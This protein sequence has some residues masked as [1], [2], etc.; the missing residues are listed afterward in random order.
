MAGAKR[1]EVTTTINVSIAGR[2]K[3]AIENHP[4]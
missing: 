3:K 1:G 4:T 2:V